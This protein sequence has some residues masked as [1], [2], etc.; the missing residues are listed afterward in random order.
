M[1][2]SERLLRMKP[3]LLLLV[4]GPAMFQDVGGTDLER[5]LNSRSTVILDRK[6]SKY[7]LS[8]MDG[9]MQ[10]PR[11]DGPWTYAPKIPNDMK[12]ISEGIQERQQQ[13][14]KE[15][16]KPPSLKQAEKD[17]K[18]PDVFVSS[19]PAELL[20]SA[21]PP[22]FEALP[23]VGLEYVKN[24]SANIFRYQASNEYFIL[25]AGRWFKSISL[26]NG[27]WNWLPPLC[28]TAFCRASCSTRKR[29]RLIS[30]GNVLGTSR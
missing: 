26:E 27:P 1:I 11:L 19:G 4:D 16:E 10:A 23:G 3:A 15:G 18:I 30:F 17:G 24:T 14:A 21:G 7:Y 22:Q 12:E 5:L 29:H 6:N 25:L 9:W 8:V 28:L 2:V 20:V 13:A